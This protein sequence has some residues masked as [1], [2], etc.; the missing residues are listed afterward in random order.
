MEP[1]VAIVVAAGS[2]SRLGGETPKA[3]RQLA[4]RPLVGH[5]LA[6][7]AAGGVHYAVLVIPAGRDD[8]FAAVVAEAPIPTTCIAGGAERQDSVL[9]GLAAIAADPELSS[10][11]FVLVHDAARA[12]VPPEVVRR[13][14]E[15]LLAGAVAAI[16][17]VPVI[18]TIREVTPGGSVTVDRG[19][20]RVVQTPQGFLRE[21]LVN[22]HRLVRETGLQVTDDAAVVEALGEP[23]T[24]V[25]GD[26]EGLKVTE[27]LDLLFAEAI[28]RSRS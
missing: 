26:R 27:P 25:A 1:V 12:L 16:P 20:L 18:D 6:G 4:G 19:R 15:A 17:V 13:V 22:G 21:A 8:E 23:V 5:C 28:V 9:A 10:A 3:L 24:L 2:G 11:R 7:L 14:I